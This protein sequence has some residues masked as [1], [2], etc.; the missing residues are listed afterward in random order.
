MEYRAL[1]TIPALHA[2]GNPCSVPVVIADAGERAALRFVEFFTVNIRNVNTR[3]AYG[4]AVRGFFAWCENTKLAVGGTEP[5][6]ACG[7]CRRRPPPRPKAVAT[8]D[9]YFRDLT[10]GTTTLVAVALNPDFK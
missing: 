1:A 9:V 4:R 7:S 2:R 3:A 8:V 10:A 5:E 6:G